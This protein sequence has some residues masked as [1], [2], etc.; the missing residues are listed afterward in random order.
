M[1]WEMLDQMNL[2]DETLCNGCNNL[3]TF[4][5][6][7]EALPKGRVQNKANNL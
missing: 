5:T 4:K 2:F 3:V 6:N 1:F 7:F